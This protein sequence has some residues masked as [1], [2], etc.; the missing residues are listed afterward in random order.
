VSDYESV[1]EEMTAVFGHIRRC[2]T[3]ADA[4]RKKL[5]EMQKNLADIDRQVA[6][7]QLALSSYVEGDIV[8][9]QI[10][11]SKRD[12]LELLRSSADNARLGVAI[13]EQAIL[14][15]ESK[16]AEFQTKY[17]ELEKELAKSIAPVIALR[18]LDSK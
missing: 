10:F 15:M 6:E 16:R 11:Q 2:A 3:L 7:G 13:E 1:R 14:K 9:I 12:N 18:S 5:P 17:L 8:S 4:S